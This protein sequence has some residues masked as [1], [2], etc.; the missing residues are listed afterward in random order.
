MKFSKL[1]FICLALIV[2]GIVF[3]TFGKF[4]KINDSVNGKVPG[5]R[6][7]LIG[8]SLELAGLLIAGYLFSKKN[9]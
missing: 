1:I 8:I 6:A 2:F 5:D 3:I 7:L 9:Q 4:L